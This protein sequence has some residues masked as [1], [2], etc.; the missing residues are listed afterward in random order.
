MITAECGI[1]GNQNLFS[2]HSHLYLGPQQTLRKKLFCVE[3]NH[4]QIG[5]SG[6]SQVPGDSCWPHN[7]LSDC[8]FPSQLFR[9]RAKLCIHAWLCTVYPERRQSWGGGG[10][11]KLTAAIAQPALSPCLCSLMPAIFLMSS[12]GEVGVMCR[13][14]ELSTET[15]SKLI[16][17]LKLT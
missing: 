11:E 15:K 17:R 9:K 14:G 5:K 1:L 12:P 3:S 2:D 4:Q 6:H 13:G 16:L 7:S 8:H 10:A